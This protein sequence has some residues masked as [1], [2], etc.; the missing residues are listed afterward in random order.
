[1]EFCLPQVTSLFL[2][3]Y[4]QTDFTDHVGNGGLGGGLD[5]AVRNLTGRPVLLGYLVIHS[6]SVP[7]G[8][9]L[10]VVVLGAV[11]LAG[12]SYGALHAVAV[13]PVISPTLRVTR[14]DGVK[15]QP[16]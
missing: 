4:G 14:P 6:L 1:G 10:H 13:D 11:R 12:S 16:D 5:H 9:P 8:D 15:S 2:L 7:P 3:G